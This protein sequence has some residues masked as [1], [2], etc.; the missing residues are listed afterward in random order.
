MFPTFSF[1]VLCEL[2]LP[3][4]ILTFF[5]SSCSK[6]QHA[7]ETSVANLNTSLIALSVAETEQ[8]R[9]CHEIIFLASLDLTQDTSIKNLISD[10]L[11]D[12]DFDERISYSLLKEEM[13]LRHNTDLVL[14][15][16][17]SIKRN[18]GSQSQI[19]SLPLI[20][21][22]FT[23]GNMM[24]RPFILI[25]FAKNVNLISLDH[26]IGKS[27]ITPTTDIELINMRTTEKARENQEIMFCREHPSWLITFRSINLT[28]RNAMWNGWLP[29]RRCTC[30][31]ACCG[32]TN[33]DAGECN[34]KW[35]DGYQKCE[36]SNFA[37]K[38]SGN[39]CTVSKAT[40]QYI[41]KWNL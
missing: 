41:P 14:Q 2:Y 13:I 6:T 34:G 25:P 27:W 7:S 9:D 16:K 28:E 19:D 30:K 4:F 22:S 31:P 40:I 35:G 29:W 23:L 21:D 5:V 18:N 8:L 15:M 26:Y 36:R 39:D 10:L 37:G 32:H 3:L 33:Q 24:F 20:I 12:E 38:C 17:R 11:S 1:K